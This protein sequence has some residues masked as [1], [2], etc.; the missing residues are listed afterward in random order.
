MAGGR[1]IGKA[2]DVWRRFRDSPLGAVLHPGVYVPQQTRTNAAGQEVIT[3]EEV[4][5]PQGP[6]RSGTVLWC[7]TTM[8]TTGGAIVAM[9]KAEIPFEGPALELAATG[10]VAAAIALW[11]HIRSWMP[12]RGAAAPQVL[13]P[14]PPAPSA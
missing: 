2:I 9:L 7:I 6:L 5:I 10:F 1:L 3:R 4:L 14:P 12:T 11:R 8:A 13:P